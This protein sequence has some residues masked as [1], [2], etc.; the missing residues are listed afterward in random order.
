MVF[1]PNDFAREGAKHKW[2]PPSGG[3]SEDNGE[4]DQKMN[5]TAANM[6]VEAKLLAEQ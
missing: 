2:R 3:N 6:Y 4:H 1:A 5:Q